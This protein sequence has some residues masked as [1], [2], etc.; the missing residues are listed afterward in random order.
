LNVGEHAKEAYADEEEFRLDYDDG[1]SE[2]V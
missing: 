1:E 2:N